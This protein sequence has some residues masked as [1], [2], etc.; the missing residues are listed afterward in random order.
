MGFKFLRQ[1]PVLYYIADFMCMELLLIIKCDG[2]SHLLEG[3]DIKDAKRQKALEKIGFK[4]LRFE[5]SIVLNNLNTTATI[6][7]QE[8]ELRKKELGLV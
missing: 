5:D 1:R 6:I 8:I 3:A 4:V 2:A 7:E